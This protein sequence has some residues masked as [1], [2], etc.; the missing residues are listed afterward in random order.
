MRLEMSCEIG[1]ASLGAVNLVKNAGVGGK[2]RSCLR[3]ATL[4][5]APTHSARQEKEHW[6]HFACGNFCDLVEDQCEHETGEQGLQHIP[7]RTK[8]GL[9]VAGDKV[10]MNKAVN[11]VAV[12]P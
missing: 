1:T 8:D 9:L 7:Q 12:F 4:E 2:S 5:V 3:D 10:A 6:R 11:Q